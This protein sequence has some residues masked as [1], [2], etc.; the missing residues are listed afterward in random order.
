MSRFRGAEVS[1][2][3]TLGTTVI[4]LVQPCP[5]KSEIIISGTEWQIALVLYVSTSWCCAGIILSGTG[6]KTG[7]SLPAVERTS[8]EL[9]SSTAMAMASSRDVIFVLSWAR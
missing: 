5:V 2:T 6:K 8:H 7:L 3:T 9:I 4:R 1:I